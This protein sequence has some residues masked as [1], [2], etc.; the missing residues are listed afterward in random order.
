MPVSMPVQRPK[1]KRG[2]GYAPTT[3][4]KAHPHLK[5]RHWMPYYWAARR[6]VIRKL[7]TRDRDTVLM[8]AEA[9]QFFSSLY[10]RPQT[11]R[12]G[13]PQERA[14][15]IL[16]NVH[17]QLK[18]RKY[19]PNSCTMFPVSLHLV[20]RMMA[21]AICLRHSGLRPKG[22]ET[23]PRYD[24]VQQARSIH[25]LLRGDRHYYT[26]D[27]GH[28]HT[29]I[30]ERRY[31][32]GLQSWNVCK[33]MSERLELIYRWYVVE[34]EQEIASRA[35]SPAQRPYRQTPAKVAARAKGCTAAKQG[36]DAR[37]VIQSQYR[38]IRRK[39]HKTPSDA[40]E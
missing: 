21:V 10:V 9:E 4:S 40:P 15:A 8:R 1:L 18:T 29:Y 26:H 2:G 23:R 25:R 6:L 28:G 37:R 5:V 12:D 34:H 30:E 39:G 17:A 16:A 11:I 24:W 32:C 20:C 35:M 22:T 3:G 38:W 13:T 14:D 33:R 27:D 7:K 19:W 31:K 36:R